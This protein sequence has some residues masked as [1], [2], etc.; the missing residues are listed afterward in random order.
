MQKTL[1]ATLATLVLAVLVVSAARA[2]DSKSL[3]QGVNVGDKAPAFEA[4]DDTG[5]AWKSED[6]VGKK[7]VVVYFFPA[8]FT[9]GCT[10]QACG[11]R[12][13]MQAL[14][15]KDVE[16]VGVSGDKVETHEKFKKEHK[17]PFTLLSDEKGELAAKLG[18]PAKVE[19]A[20]A[21]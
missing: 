5:K 18:V 11:Y 1:Q 7:I 3:I 4:K 12:D 19:A 13:D 14:T 10:K 9:G 6:H 17:L 2:D 20:T 16:V 21:K 8:D 15:D